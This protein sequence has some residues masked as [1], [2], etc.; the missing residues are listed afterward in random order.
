MK[1]SSRYIEPMSTM[2][3]LTA[4]DLERLN[5]PNRRTELVRGVLI[6]R[7]PAGFDHG[8][9]AMRIGAAL[10]AYVEAHRFGVVLAAETGF[11]IT[12]TANVL[13]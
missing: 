12:R 5:L 10:L 8:K 7:E 2:A 9:V 1:N 13:R 4:E 11:V 3:L 6:V